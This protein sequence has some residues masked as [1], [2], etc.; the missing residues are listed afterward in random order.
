MVRIDHMKAASAY[1]AV[2][3]EAIPRWFLKGSDGTICRL[4][5]CRSGAVQ[6]GRTAC[7]VNLFART[8]KWIPTSCW[9]VVS[10]WRWLLQ[11]GAS[12]SS[13]DALYHVRHVHQVRRAPEASPAGTVQ[14]REPGAPQASRPA[15]KANMTAR[16]AGF[17]YLYQEPATSGSIRWCERVRPRIGHVCR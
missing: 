2:S 4:R 16:V 6:K 14:G 17:I 1:M 10:V 9:A 5:A 3:H 15:I 11:S 8:L 13:V 7:N 12:G